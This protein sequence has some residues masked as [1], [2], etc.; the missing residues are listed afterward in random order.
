MKFSL[1]LSLDVNQI[2]AYDDEAI[3]VR[4]KDSTDLVTIDA[5]LILTPSQIITDDAIGE[6]T[7][8]SDG[9]IRY[10]KNLEPEILIIVQRSGLHFP[11]E[12]RAK[13]SELAIG[14]ESMTLGA[15]CRTYNLLV[16]EGRKVI[17]LANFT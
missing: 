17:L 4:I 11:I 3:T 10:L 5:N 16:A 6:L 7:N 2:H 9:D 8:L 13:F 14:I 1:E 12:T 15:A